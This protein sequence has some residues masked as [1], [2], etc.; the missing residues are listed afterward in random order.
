[1][2]YSMALFKEELFL[3]QYVAK[4]QKQ[5]CTLGISLL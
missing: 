3:L 2:L 5:T 4:T 1:M